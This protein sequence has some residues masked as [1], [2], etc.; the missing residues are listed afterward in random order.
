MQ[1]NLIIVIDT[2]RSRGNISARS[3]DAISFVG[4]V[5]IEAPSMSV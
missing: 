5:V 2:R 4:H 3:V 1:E